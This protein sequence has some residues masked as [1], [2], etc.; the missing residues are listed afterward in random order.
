MKLTKFNHSCILLEDQAGDKLITDTGIFTYLPKDI[1][2][3]KVLIITH[4]HPDHFKQE[5]V[6]AIKKVNQDLKIFA[7]EDIAATIDAT[8]PILGTEYK[9]GSFE[10][11]FYS[12]DHAYIRKDFELPNNLGVIIN[13]QISYPGDSYSLSPLKTKY[14]LTPLTAPWARIKDTEEFIVNSIP[15]VVIPVHDAILSENGYLIYDTHLK[16]IAENN[17]LEY[18]RLTVGESINL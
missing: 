3:I 2:K 7:P 13:K 9:V 15:E 4:N 12:S 5:S 18:K 6:E 16:A 17:D 14:L 11:S 8:I 10:I 1:S